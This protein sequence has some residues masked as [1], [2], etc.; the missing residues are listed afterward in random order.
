VVYTPPKSSFIERL[1][2]AFEAYA[3]R[4]CVK[5]GDHAY[6]YA[7]VNKLS[8]YIATD[9][10]DKGF[11]KGDFGAVYSENSARVLIVV[12]GIL[13]AGGVWIPVNPRNSESENERVLS[14]LCCKTIFYQKRFFQAVK[15]VKQALGSEL[16][17]VDI[18]QPNYSADSVPEVDAPEIEFALTDLVSLPFTGGTT[19]TPKGVLLSNANFNAISY[20]VSRW[21]KDYDSQPISLCVA[22]MTH[23]GG[24]VALAA[25]ISG[26]CLLVHQ[27]F[28]TRAVLRTIQE[29]QATDVF[30]PPTAIYSMLEEPALAEFDHSSLRTILYGSAPIS[31]EKLKQALRVFGPVMRSAYG[32]TECPTFIAELTPE[33]HFINGELAP[34]ERLRSVG[35]ATALSEIAIVDENCDPLPTGE[36]GEIATKGAMVCEGYYQ[37]AEETAKIHVKGWHL[38]GDIGYLDADGFLYLVDRKKD[39]IVTGGFNVYSSE[40]ENVINQISGVHLSQ[41][42]GVPSERWGEEV[43]GLVQLEVGSDLDQE[44]ILA[45]CRD[46]LGSVKTP[47]TIEYRDSFPLTSLGKIDKKAI[48]AEFWADRH[49][50]I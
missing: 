10:A 49:T 6:S 47:K 41:V 36:L 1:E 29:E 4:P 20:G 46:A 40:V 18:D 17:C 39:M 24:R 33:D 48:R 9:L 8:R 12:L 43:K 19:G 21:Y 42:I 32:Q 31:L 35:H 11:E 37:S 3:D 28:D 2:L 14:T 13:R 34:D 15:R 30:L 22:P 25:M 45:I 5:F 16:I 26:A 23:V 44:Q 27:S 50:N 38:T 7:E